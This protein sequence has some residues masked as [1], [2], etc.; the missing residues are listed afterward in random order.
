M[1][2]KLNTPLRREIQIK[3]KPYTLTVDLLQLKLVEKGKR[4]GLELTWEDLVSG[5]AAV[6]RALSAALIWKAEQKSD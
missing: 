4:K 3:G 1:T 2:T 6:A 5:A